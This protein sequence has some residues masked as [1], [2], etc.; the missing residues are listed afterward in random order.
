[1]IKNREELTKRNIPYQE[2][3]K[4]LEFDS[5]VSDEVCNH[6]EEAL[7]KMGILDAL[8]VD[9]SYQ[10]TVLSMYEGG[11]DR[12]YLPHKNVPSIAFLTYFLLHQT[13][14]FL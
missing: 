14:I 7:L 2:F 5:S 9:E 12:Y 1:M 6:L 10:D 13:M 8:V 11:C 3:Y 4:L